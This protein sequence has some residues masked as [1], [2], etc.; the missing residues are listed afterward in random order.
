M[1]RPSAVDGTAM[2]ASSG[3]SVPAVTPATGI[4][5]SSSAANSRPRAVEA[6]ISSAASG[7]SPSGQPGS[8]MRGH[9]IRNAP[10]LASR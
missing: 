1:L 10:A 5:G 2:A 7:A 6:R 9:S 8:G 3:R 4:S